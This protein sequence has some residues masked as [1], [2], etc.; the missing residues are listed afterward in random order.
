MIDLLTAS[1]KYL[2]HVQDAIKS[3]INTKDR[4]CKTARPGWRS[5]V[6]F[7]LQLDNESIFDRDGHL[8]FQH[9]ING[10]VKELS[11]TWKVHQCRDR[12]TLSFSRH[13]MDVTSSCWPKVVL[14][15]YFIHPAQLN[16]LPP[17]S[18]VLLPVGVKPVVT[19]FSF[20]SYLQV[21]YCHYSF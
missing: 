17:L 12:G 7:W 2:I 4:S 16:R 8:A 10:P 14:N 13:W 9:V 11:Q 20:P 5:S 21:F 18:R 3:T 6:K 19:I 1:G 15:Y